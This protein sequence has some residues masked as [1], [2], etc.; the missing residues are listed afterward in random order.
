[1]REARLRAEQ[2]ARNIAM[3]QMRQ[4]IAQ[5]DR[6][7]IAQK[8]REKSAL[9]DA[10]KIWTDPATRL[11]WV[12]EDNGSDVNWQKAGNYCRNLRLGGYSD[13]RL[14]SIDELSGIY[15]PNA[16]IEGEQGRGT[17]ATWHVKGKL[18][19]SGYQWSSSQGNSAWEAWIFFFSNGARYSSP[20]LGSGLYRALCVRNSGE[21]P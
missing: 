2:Q 8:A 3:Q 18:Q 17:R 9:E 6:D 14:P 11:M 13:W 15:D 7:K 20:L 10:D 16:N 12:K 1:V 21:R 19:L 4:K 5:E